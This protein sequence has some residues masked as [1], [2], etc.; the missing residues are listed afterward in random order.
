MRKFNIHTM[1]CKSNQFE[2][3]IIIENLKNNGLEEVKNINDADV[4]SSPHY[5]LKPNDIIYV[6]PLKS[7]QYGF[8]T[9]PYGT[10][11]SALSLIITCITFGVAF[12]KP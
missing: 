11:F 4:L 3:S 12:I 1:G 8:T 9:M 2:S 7:K 6:E 5:Y 10:I